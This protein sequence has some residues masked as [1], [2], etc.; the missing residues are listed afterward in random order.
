MQWIYDAI[1]KIITLCLCW[2]LFSLR[3]PYWSRHTGYFH[4]YVMHL[5]SKARKTS[6]KKHQVLFFFCS[7]NEITSNFGLS[8]NSLFIFP[9]TKWQSSDDAQ[10]R[11]KITFNGRLQN[12]R[13]DSCQVNRWIILTETWD[14]ILAR[15][16]VHSRISIVESNTY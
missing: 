12:N 15:L 6:R 14:R 3:S 5:W 10:S 13:T 11:R 9:V 16:F 8:T 7:C 2:W 4:R 1:L